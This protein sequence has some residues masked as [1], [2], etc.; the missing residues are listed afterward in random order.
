[1]QQDSKDESRAPGGSTESH[2]SLAAQI[3]L[4]VVAACPPEVSGGSGML[5]S[6]NGPGGK[7][8]GKVIL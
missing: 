6:Q 4:D 8:K 7:K 1:M 5:L 3:I 2:R